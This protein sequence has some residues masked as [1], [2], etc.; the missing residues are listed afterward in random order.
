VVSYPYEWCFSMLR[1]AALLQLDLLLAALDE[2]MTL[3]DATPFNVQWFGT[4]PVFIDTGSF[5][6]ADPGTPWLGYRQFCEMF[7]YPL[8]LQ[9]YKGVP[10]QPWL[11]GSLEGLD[12]GHV[13]RLMSLRDRLR[14]GVFTHVYLLSKAQS[15]YS[16]TSRDVRQELRSAGFG[17]ALVKANVTRMR[18]TVERLRWNAGRSTWS[19]YADTNSYDPENR[20]R[21]LR[22][23]REAARSQRRAV[24]WDLGCNTGEYSR[25]V[26][27]S[28]DLVVALDADH[29]AIERL[30]RALAQENDT[31]ILP[32]VADLTNPSPG[33]GWRNLERRTLLDRT[34]PD[35]ILA[36]ALI[37]HLAIARNVPLPEIVDWLASFGSEVVVEFPGPG[38]PMVQRLL[39]NR[40][41]LDFG[42][43]RARFEAELERHFSTVAVDQLLSGQRTIY[44]LRPR[45]IAG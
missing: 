29:L 30:Y 33:V 4:R 14:P 32:L 2:N 22:F 9:A 31:T 43:T 39:R 15:R 27:E 24:V 13:N 17:P 34:R 6:R 45:A 37:H 18:R 11:R 3:K 1:D 35:L 28:A 21:K 40:G 20:D 8:L 41:D 12:A 10:F 25:A 19:E 42:Y 7:L 44:H 16:E 5:T 36:L 26:R 23:V 38:D